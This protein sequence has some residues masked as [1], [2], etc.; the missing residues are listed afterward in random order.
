MAS[1]W[2][3]K[4]TAGLVQYTREMNPQLRHRPQ[5]HV[6]WSWAGWLVVAAV[7]LAALFLGR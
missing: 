1:F 7:A 4:P 2:K 3:G 5:I 6:G